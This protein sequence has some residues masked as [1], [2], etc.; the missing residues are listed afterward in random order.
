MKLT[1]LHTLQY[2]SVAGS[3]ITMFTAEAGWELTAQAELGGVIAKKGDET[4]WIPFTN[5]RNGFPEKTP[6]AK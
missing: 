5:C 1:K 6:K 3:T 2:C 4:I